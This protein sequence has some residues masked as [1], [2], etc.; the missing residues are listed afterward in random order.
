MTHV[1]SSRTKIHR[2]QLKHL[3]HL[4]PAIMSTHHTADMLHTSYFITGDVLA[5]SFVL[6]H[7]GPSIY[8]CLSARSALVAK[9]L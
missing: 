7:S 2:H 8:L 4:H 9:L 3:H 6:S 1:D 5:N